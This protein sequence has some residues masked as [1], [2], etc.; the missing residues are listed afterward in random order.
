MAGWR[1]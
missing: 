1:A